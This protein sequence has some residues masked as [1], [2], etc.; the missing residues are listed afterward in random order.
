MRLFFIIQEQIGMKP[1][2]AN[3]AKLNDRCVSVQPDSPGL[4]AGVLKHQMVKPSAIPTVWMPTNVADYASAKIVLH[5]QGGA[6]V[7]ASDPVGIGTPAAEIFLK[8]LSAVTLYAQ[9]RL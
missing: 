4:F 3:P 6:F 1:L 5:S 8:E 9:Y 2:F 7:L